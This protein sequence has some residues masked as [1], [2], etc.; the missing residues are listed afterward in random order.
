MRTAR[1]VTR[2][3]L[4]VEKKAWAFEAYA[5]EIYWHSQKGRFSRT[6]VE[7]PEERE[8]DMLNIYGRV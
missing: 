6:V 5:M 2:P 8:M 1:D 4:H 3:S 7:Q